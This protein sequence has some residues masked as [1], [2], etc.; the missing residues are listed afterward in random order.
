VL[1]VGIADGRFYVY[2]GGKEKAACELNA[3]ALARTHVKLGYD[4][5]NDNHARSRS[6]SMDFPRA[7]EPA[8]SDLGRMR[9]RGRI[10]RRA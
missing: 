5:S 2:S 6:S 8:T 1:V 4:A 9:S 7:C 3:G 10:C